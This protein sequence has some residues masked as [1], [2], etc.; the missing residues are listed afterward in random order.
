MDPRNEIFP[1][2]WGEEVL[3]APKMIVVGTK[4]TEVRVNVTGL[5]EG[6]SD[7]MVCSIFVPDK[8]GRHPQPRK[9]TKQKKVEQYCEDSIRYLAR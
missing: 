5:M 8:A 2:S 4:L 7:K 6:H 1:N 3:D 9:E